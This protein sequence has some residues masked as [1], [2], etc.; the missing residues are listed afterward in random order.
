MVI[1][2]LAG[3]GILA[4]RRGSR[5]CPPFREPTS[6]RYIYIY[7]HIYIYIYIYTYIY[8]YLQTKVGRDPVSSKFLAQATKPHR[9]AATPET[10]TEPHTVSKLFR[11]CAKP[12]PTPPRLIQPYESWGILWGLK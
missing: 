7:I 4:G 3:V 12:G 8:I 1:S 6:E 11:T 5:H 2:K 9:G 10:P